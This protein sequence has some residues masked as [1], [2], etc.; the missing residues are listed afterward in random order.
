MH[1]NL[2]TCLYSNVVLEGATSTSTVLMAS[3]PMEHLSRN[4]MI[5]TGTLRGKSFKPIII[6]M[7]QLI[8]ELGDQKN[9]L[10]I[11]PSC[12]LRNSIGAWP[13]SQLVNQQHHLRTA[14]CNIV[15]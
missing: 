10:R 12:T 15:Q 1:A 6:V 9:V 2:N 5:S 4:G 11:P 7:L 8:D 13:R 3:S 14:I